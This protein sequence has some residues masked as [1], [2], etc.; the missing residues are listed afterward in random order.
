M[1]PQ[2]VWTRRLALSEFRILL[3]ESLHLLRKSP[4]GR[5]ALRICIPAWAVDTLAREKFRNAMQR[6]RVAQT[7]LPPSNC[8]VSPRGMAETPEEETY[9]NQSK[10]PDGWD[11]AKAAVEPRETV[12]SV[13]YELVP[14]TGS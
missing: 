1:S 4:G 5:F 7:G 11:E 10:F 12:M 8:Q 6:G 14:E 2:V 3:T 13:P 9:M